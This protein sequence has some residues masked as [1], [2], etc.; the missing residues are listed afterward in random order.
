[1]LKFGKNICQRKLFAA[2]ENGDFKK[3]FKKT[4]FTIK[5]NFVQIFPFC[6]Y[7]KIP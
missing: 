6:F 1:M 2:E 7:C 3:L 5:K 4:F